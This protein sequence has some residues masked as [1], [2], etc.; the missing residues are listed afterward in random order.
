[1]RHPIRLVIRKIWVRRY[2]AE[3]KVLKPNLFAACFKLWLHKGQ[4]MVGLY[5]RDEGDIAGSNQYFQKYL[6]SN[7]P[8]SGQIEQVMR[9]G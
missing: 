8:D 6:D 2:I 3:V 7:P 1:M 9:G 4:Q 5:Q